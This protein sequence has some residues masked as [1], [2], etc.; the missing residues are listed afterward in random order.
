MAQNTDKQ[1]LTQ[2]RDNDGLIPR[3]GGYENTKPWQLADLIYDITVLFCDKYV[4]R[5]S[6][7]HDQMVQAAR[8]GAQNLQEGSVDSAG[9]KKIELKLTGIARGSLKE[10]QRDYQKF[11]KHRDL[12]EW[13]PSH[14]A[15]TRFKALQCATLE[16][17][18]EWVAKETRLAQQNTDTRGQTS[19]LS[20]SFLPSVRVSPCSSVSFPSAFPAVCAANG[21]LALLNLCVYLIAR[22]MEAQADAFE[23]EGGFTERLYKRR[24]EYRKQRTG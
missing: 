24:A 16:Q 5:R 8:S 4:D 9:S 14:P 3:H 17:F 6:R 2:A 10:L 15:L 23:K 21:A 18:R 22:Q 19:V 11:L 20:G 7:T 1:R 13:P 12:P